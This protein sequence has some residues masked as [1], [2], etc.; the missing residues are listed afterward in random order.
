M[1]N[2]TTLSNENKKT[3]INEL[4]QFIKIQSVSADL[5]KS[6][7]MEKAV[8][9]LQNKLQKLGFVAEI[10]K[11]EGSAPMI[12]AKK[13]IIGAKKT[14]A[15]YGHYD[16]QS[17]DPIGEWDSDPFILTEKNGKYFGR[18]VAD[19]KGHVIQNI[20]AI[21]NLIASQSLKSNI[22][23]IIEGEEESGSSHLENY[24]LTKA[25]ELKKVDEFYITDLEMFQKGTPMIVNALRGLVYFEV[26]LKIGKRDL[27]SGVYGNAVLNPAQI[28]ANLMASMKDIMTGE[29]SIPGFYDNVREFSKVE[30]N[31]LR[32]A[33]TI[34]PHSATVK[35]SCRLVE[36]QKAVEI[37]K[38]VR[39]YIESFFAAKKPF[40]QLS[41]KLSI[42]TLS[43]DDPFFC[44][45]D[46]PVIQRAADIMSMHFGK[47]TV[48]MREGGSIPAAEIIER[49]FGVSV[50][51]TGFILPDSNLHAPNENFD[52]EMFWE[53]IEVMKKI[54]S[55]I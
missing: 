35:F 28:L 53:G 44:S 23:F 7:E 45:I 41:V 29:V 47:K 24:L 1:M 11:N 19:N 52:E 32:A 43:S 17:E 38:L 25:E 5:H 33:K 27:H 36:N 21:E 42:K 9:F 12:F 2:S 51:L 13:D 50:V 26:K 39:D 37:E 40:P 6:Q 31:I 14:V 18:G 10:L 54:Y 8:K 49:L 46:S 22:I 4:S 16:V 34:I 3:I 20:A 30:L 55:G 48:F 15:I